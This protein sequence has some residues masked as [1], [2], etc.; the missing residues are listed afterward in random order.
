[1]FRPARAALRATAALIVVLPA[2][3][4]VSSPPAC[5][6]P[7]DYQAEDATI[8]QGAVES[9]HTGYTGS[10]FVNYNNVVGSYVEW[11]IP[12]ATAGN[13]SVAI[14]Y[15]NGVASGTSVD[16]PM[17]IS[18]NGTLVRSALSFPS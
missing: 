8:S 7:V 2:L 10:G 12:A 13:V 4:V 5:A 16:R 11:S 1:M 3:L 6:A 15:A 14:R 17:D 9:N 18:V